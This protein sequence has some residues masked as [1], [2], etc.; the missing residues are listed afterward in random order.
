MWFLL[1][2]LQLL[3]LA[4]YYTGWLDHMFQDEAYVVL[5]V[6]A[7]LK[8]TF[9]YRDWYSYL[10][11]GSYFQA[12]PW[13]SLAGTGQF[14]TRSTMALLAA[15][16]GLVIWRLAGPLSFSWRGFA[17]LVWACLGM[18]EIPILNYH[19]F[20]IFWFSLTVVAARRWVRGEHRFAPWVGAGVALA[21]W[22]L[23]SEGL[24][25]VLLIAACGVLFRPPGLAR[26]WLGLLGA[27]LLLWGPF[28]PWLPEIWQQS[29]LSLKAHQRW[30]FFRYNWSELTPTWEAAR[31][32]LPGADPLGWSYAWLLF[33]VRSLKYGALPLW[34]GLSAV[35]AWRSRDRD[36][37]VLALATILLFLANSNRQTL[38]YLSYELAL[39]IPLCAH[40]LYHLPRGTWVRNGLAVLVMA[41]WTAN[42]CIWQRDAKIPIDT[43]TGRYWTD[44]VYQR[45]LYEILGGWATLCGQDPRGALCQEYQPHLYS[46]WNIRVPIAE[47]TLVPLQASLESVQQAARR[48]DEQEIPWIIYV[49]SDPAATAAEHT[50]I[51][52]EEF[53]RC[54]AEFYQ[55]LTQHYEV[56]EQVDVLQLLRRKKR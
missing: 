37:Q 22:S 29:V 56:A 30:A 52:A 14:G 21:G 6:R 33:L 41:F 1:V 9:P 12:L 43:P 18:M 31:A 19:W 42:F 45:R 39:A 15:A 23:Q 3:L 53:A 28:L 16:Q 34:V 54:Q 44:S 55:T 36:L 8:G 13:M 40:Q 46:L 32:S 35:Q 4:P 24:A 11:P 26:A 25:G 10:S 38:H 49:P 5:G 2:A 47:I 48:L 27:S 7:L 20:S 17:W 50:R 51:T